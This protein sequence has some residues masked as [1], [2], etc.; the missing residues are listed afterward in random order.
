MNLEIRLQKLERIAGKRK[1]ITDD[2]ERI[3][4]CK[5]SGI[6]IVI[7]GWT[8]AETRQILQI[9]N[10]ESCP[11]CKGKYISV[12]ID[13]NALDIEQRLEHERIRNQNTRAG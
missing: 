9:D 4:N 10:P 5:K 6:H 12:E 13:E 1:Q 2:P 11:K 7:T 3:C 8:E